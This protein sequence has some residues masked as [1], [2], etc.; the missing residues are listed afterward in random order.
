M[1][2]DGYTRDDVVF[3]SD[4]HR[5][6]AHL[7]RPAD[8]LPGDAA[9]P[10]VISLTGYSGRK[11]V[12]TVDIPRRLAREGFVALAP[13]YVGYGEAEGPRRRHRPLEQAQ[14]V[15]DA[16]TFLETVDGVDAARIGVY[17]SSFGA[18]NAVWAAA[19][20]P[21]GLAAPYGLRTAEKRHPKYFC[22]RKRPG[23][24]GGCCNWSG[25]MW[26]FETAKAISAAIN[27]LNDYPTV[28]TVD[29]DKL[30]LMLWQY[31]AS[32]TP[33]WKVVNTTA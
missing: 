15:Y 22:D 6:T 14:N 16:A 25:P 30:W 17:G 23:G 12:A 21:M 24:G 26:P 3:Y 29:R 13:D 1:A 11:N 7:Y 27:V 31:A 5:I 18:A 4:G 33:L 10:A 28:T 9:L 2:E 8:W 32:H 20:D 19:F